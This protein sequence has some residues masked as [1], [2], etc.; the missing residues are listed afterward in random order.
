MSI[1]ISK[2]DQRFTSLKIILK[3]L[4]KKDHTSTL[5]TLK[6]LLIEPNYI[7][8]TDGR[9]LHYMPNLPMLTPGT[10]ALI[11]ANATEI[12]LNPV[13]PA[14][15]GKY[16]DWRLVTGIS[17]NTIETTTDINILL[18]I[19]GNLGICVDHKHLRDILGNRTETIKLYCTDGQQPI[20]LKINDITCVIMNV[21]PPN[22]ITKP[23]TADEQTVLKVNV[24][25][26]GENNEP[27]KPESV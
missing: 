22:Y 25:P 4:S 14:E 21:I 18:Y 11:K 16:P 3:A 12:I 20:T 5:K 17:T 9:R 1:T 27:S 13:S 8:A 23:A 19:L 24:I 2:N 7:V 6:H 15:V 10:Y 26:N